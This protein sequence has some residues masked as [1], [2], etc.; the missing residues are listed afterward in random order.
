MTDLAQTSD[1]AL[2]AWV[3]GTERYATLVDFDDDWPE[4]VCT[5]PYDDTCKHAVALV[6]AFQQCDVN[7][8]LPV[9][10]PDDRRL[11]LLELEDDGDEEDG[12]ERAVDATLQTY[13]A[14]LPQEH[15]AGLLLD[16]AA[17]FP[18]VRRALSDR[19]VLT[20]N[21]SALLVRDIQRLL[22]QAN[23]YSPSYDEWDDY[24]DEDDEDGP[25][26][27][28]IRERLAHLLAQRE[29]DKVVAFGDELLATGK[30]LIEETDDEDGELQSDVGDCMKVV[31]QALRQASKPLPER[32]Q[33]A[34][35]WILADEY[36]L[37]S[38]A[39]VFLDHAADQASWGQVA[40]KLLR[41]LG[42]H[43]PGQSLAAKVRGRTG[44]VLPRSA[45]EQTPVSSFRQMYEREKQ[46]EWAIRALERAGRAEEILPLCE[47]EAEH[48]HS[49]VRLVKRLIA[50]G[51][52]GEAEEWIAKGIVA[53][54]ASEP[55]IASQLLDLQMELWEQAGEWAKIAARRASL[56][57][58]SPSLQDLRALRAA[59]ERADVWPQVRAAAL[60]YLETGERPGQAPRKGRPA[61]PALPLPELPAVM[62]EDTQHQRYAV[63]PAVRLLVD[64][65]LEEQR[66][67]DALRWYEQRGN[68]PPGGIQLTSDYAIKVAQAI[69][70]T[71]P[72]EAAAIWRQLADQAITSG[73]SSNYPAAGDYLRK[74]HGL[75]KR[76]SRLDEWRGYLGHLRRQ[77]ARKRRFIEILDQLE[78]L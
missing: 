20:S 48:N 7:R 28:A 46:S 4:S 39:G 56:F 44:Q 22:D 66:P 1:G 35:D 38:H 47:R 10:G 13:L 65:A 29:A 57:F 75:L 21:N 26:F 3:Q 77:H 16:L 5:C 37:C 11:R 34:V 9:A 69:D 78:R 17:Q 54:R 43:A 8:P 18:E 67:E 72:D 14:S 73:Y 55:G 60:H 27:G 63:F 45:V 42:P 53:T 19:L 24:D 50:A 25:D 12:P 49:Y 6:L 62:A 36:D 51:R 59:A 76:Q 2:L 71:H 31:F 23:R 52:A 40:D 32:L 61:P 33:Q 64:L 70:T 30:R 74:L 41:R 68:I 15:L 58:H